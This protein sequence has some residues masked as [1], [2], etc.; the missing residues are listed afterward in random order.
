MSLSITS[1]QNSTM[2][3]LLSAINRNTLM[4]NTAIQRLST[5]LRINAGKDDPA[6]LIA[7][8]QLEAEIKAVDTASANAS[9]ADAMLN[10]A[11]GALSEVSS[12]LTEIQ[13]LAVANASDS[14]LTDAEKSANQAQIDSAISSIDRIVNTTTFN[15]KRLLDGTQGVSVSGVDTTELQ[16]VRVFGRPSTSGDVSVS[17]SLTSGATQ[18][19]VT[20]Y[21]TTS[22]STATQITVTGNLGTATIS[23][24]AGEN[25]SS[26]ASK[27]NNSSAETGVT[28]SATAANDNLSLVAQDYG[29]D[30]YV[31]VESVSGDS[32]AFGDQAQTSGSD[33]VVTV[34]GQ[35]A[36]VD[37]RDVSYNG[38]GVNLE[39]SLTSAF[40]QTGSGSSSFTV[41]SGGATFAIG[42]N[43]GSSVTIGVPSL[44]SANIGSTVLGSL[45]TVKSG[46]G[47]ST[48][49]NA[50][51]AIGIVRDAVSQVA[52][53]RGRI[54]GFQKYQLQSSINSLNNTST[55]LQSAK[56]SILDA[57][58]AAESASLNRQQLL[59]STGMSLLGIVNQ[60]QASV[61][62]LLSL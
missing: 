7:V 15:G 49:Q 35:T 46:G 14:T 9:R 6:G 24:T 44:S 26:V 20:G 28:A 38:A 57:D 27:I 52:R 17:V 32:T 36:S 33:A 54:G 3:N 23:I 13:G 56:S 40:N 61:L 43:A 12:L 11:D 42:P 30:G 10:I 51:A 16:D 47:N 62:S 4:M 22:A 53:D 59:V 39:F 8:K 55:S 60:Q 58:M 25:L 50:S 41:S 37:G 34:N 48:L 19:T 45:A 29:D 18:G 31:T 1:S 5:G 21:A 2:Q